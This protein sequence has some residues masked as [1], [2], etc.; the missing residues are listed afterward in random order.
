MLKR[1]LPIL[2]LLTACSSQQVQQGV[3]LPRDARWALL[4]LVNLSEAPRAGERARRLVE[5]AL[6]ARG[7]EPVLAPTPRARQELPLLDDRVR[8]DE[9]LA[10][11]RRERI[12]YAV[13]GSVEEWRYKSGLDGEPAVGLSLRI[14]EIPEGRVVW[15]GSGSRTGWGYD[16]LSGTATRVIDDLLD[17]LRLET[18]TPAN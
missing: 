8:L 2:L 12:H 3:T 18:G 14:V 11:A 13:T 16:N 4:P 6:R 5:A 9:A 10:W 7:L 15:V 1:L 17:A